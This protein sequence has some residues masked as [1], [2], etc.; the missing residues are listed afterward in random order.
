MAKQTSCYLTK[1]ANIGVQTLVNADSAPAANAGTSP[2]NTKLL[3]TAGADGAVVNSIIVASD[4][5]AAKY[6]SI[7]YEQSG[8]ALKYLIGTVAVAITS[9]MGSTGV[10]VNVDFLGNAYI[11]GLNLNQSGRPVL[12]LEGGD[13][14]YCSLVPGGT[15]VTASK[16]LW[17]QAFGEDF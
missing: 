7:W 4:D 13:K 15:A 17:I 2:T 8:S 6:V 16:T 1:E 14:L 10:V 5:T 12:N 11:A 9:G 3:F